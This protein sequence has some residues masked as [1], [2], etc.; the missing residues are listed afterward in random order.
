[1]HLLAWLSIQV[2]ST[3][4]LCCHKC[5]RLTS[6][7]HNRPHTT[8]GIKYI[9]YT[10]RPRPHAHT[11]RYSVLEDDNSTDA[12][13]EEDTV[14]DDSSAMDCRLAGMEG[15]DTDTEMETGTL[16]VAG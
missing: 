2:A 3:L 8:Y 4:H 14:E 11:T 5:F 15:G 9:H 7:R 16:T 12:V 13:I 10:P 1:M 6:T